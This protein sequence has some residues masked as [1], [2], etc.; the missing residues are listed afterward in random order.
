MGYSPH[1]SFHE[2]SPDA[3]VVR[4]SRGPIDVCQASVI[5]PETDD[6]L[7]LPT[8]VTRDAQ[9]GGREH[10]VLRVDG[11]ESRAEDGNDARR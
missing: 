9:R 6:L 7:V 4:V 1:Q 11:S 8:V 3:F 5:V 10:K 2:F